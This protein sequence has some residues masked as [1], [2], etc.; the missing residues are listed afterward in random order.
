MTLIALLT[1]FVTGCATMPSSSGI[2]VAT[3]EPRRAHAAAL[4]DDGG[5]LSLDTG[6]R[7]LTRL[8]AGCAG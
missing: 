3:E 1:L 2:C 4:L 5:P 6:E 7:L 8:A